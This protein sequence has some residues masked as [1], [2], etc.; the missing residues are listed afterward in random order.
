MK[1]KLTFSD[2]LF[3]AENSFLAETKCFALVWRQSFG[4]T[5]FDRMDIFLLLVQTTHLFLLTYVS[6]HTATDGVARIDFSLTPKPWPGIKL[7]SAQLHLFLGTLTQGALP[8]ELP[9]PQLDRM[10][11]HLIVLYPMA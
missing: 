1:K 2:D 7:K 5:T 11:I 8:T 10:Y 6:P 3:S 9:Q 4:A